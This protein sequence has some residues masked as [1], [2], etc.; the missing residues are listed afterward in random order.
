MRLSKMITCGIILSVLYP[1]FASAAIPSAGE[2]VAGRLPDGTFVFIVTSGMEQLRPVFDQSSIG[3]LW[4]DP[5]VQ[6]FYIQT[7]DAVMGKIKEEAAKS[8]DEVGSEIISMLPNLAAEAI[9]CP[10]AIGFVEVTEPSPVPFGVFAIVEAGKHK[11]QIQSLIEQIEN[12]IGKDEIVDKTIGGITFHAP[13]D[14]EAPIFW[15]WHNDRFVVVFNNP[16]GQWLNGLNAPAAKPSPLARLEGS[17]DLVAL[18]CD[19]QKI[20]GM[21]TK[22]MENEGQGDDLEKIRKVMDSLGLRKVRTLTMRTGFAGKDIVTDQLLEAPSPRTGIFTA[23]KP[24]DLKEFARTDARSMTTAAWNVDWA[25]LYDM[26]IKAVNNAMDTDEQRQEIQSG[27][28][29]LEAK[30]GIQIRQGLLAGLDGSMTMQAYPG[31]VMPEMPLGG[32]GLIAG[33]RDAALFDQQIATLTAMVSKEAKP[34]VVQIVTQTREDGKKQTT[35]MSPMLGLMQLVP[36]WITSGNRW[37]LTTNPSLTK[38]LLTQQGP[39]NSDY[40]PLGEDKTYQAM[41]TKLPGGIVLM[42]YSDTAASF[43]QTYQ[44]IQG[45]WPMVMGAA[46]GQGI[47]LPT[48]LPDIHTH[49]EGLGKSVGYSYLTADG[50]RTYYRGSG[51]ESSPNVAMGGGAMAAA[52]LMPAVSKARSTAQRVV[53]ATNLKLI[54]L[55][56]HTYADDH[57]DSFPEDLDVLLKEGRIEEK[58]LTSPQKPKGFSGPS[59]VYIVGQKP[60]GAYDNIL[61]Y[62]QPS[63][64]KDSTVNVLFIDGHVEAMNKTRFDEKLKKTYE[65]LGRPVPDN[66]GGSK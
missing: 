11:A 64:S 42:K 16:S 45:F 26:I 10:M 9:Q 46:S 2:N 59:Y 56:C 54:G 36:N 5:E 7:R 8:G 3:R 27:I 34:G 17:G 58:T 63:F 66:G 20:G 31:G 47:V 62:E 61:A 55:A 23:I 33:L 53:S 30:A 49:I 32:L 43:K 51:L 24:V 21:V 1:C 60:S 37:I 65:N 57:E 29:D 18:Y 52:I 28:A 4:N 48:M 14:E 40:T 25:M 19:F 15:G 39:E 12:K 50:L 41:T 35:V 44:Q 6:S 13:N 22:I 38:M